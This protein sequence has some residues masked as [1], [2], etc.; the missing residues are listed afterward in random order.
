MSRL[1]LVVGLAALAFFAST[2]V[3]LRLHEPPLSALELGP[4]VLLRSGHI[5]LLFGGLLNV[6]SSFRGELRRGKGVFRVGSIL[7]LSSPVLLAVGFCLE[8]T[9]SMLERP[10]TKLGVIAAWAGV[11]LQFI[12]FTIAAWK[13][14]QAP[15]TE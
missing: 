1:H 2:G 8:S 5:Y 14:K 6:V 13:A 12:G 11:L 7:L 4:N 9:G 3:Y 15:G 10:L